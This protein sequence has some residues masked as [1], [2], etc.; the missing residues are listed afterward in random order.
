MSKIFLTAD[1]HFGHDNIIKNCNRP[2]KDVDEMNAVLIDNWNSVINKKDII[3]HLGDIVCFRKNE[4]L[5]DILKQLNGRI[6]L[7]LGNH[8]NIKKK[9][10]Q[11]F[12]SIEQLKTI[13]YKGIKIVLCHYA[14]RVWNCSCHGSLHF[15]AHSHGML[16]IKANSMDVG[17][18]C[19]NFKPLFI[20]DA[21][22]MLN[23]AS[24]PV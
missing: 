6:H 4:Y 19:H 17:V 3:Y 8:D 22:D 13:K 1:H 18:D 21:I 10:Y 7:I 9:N 14:M 20:E 15:Y 24:K 2:F 12:D 23:N 5:I 11:L 16:P